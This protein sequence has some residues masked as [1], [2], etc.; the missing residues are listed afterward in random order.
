MKL[1]YDCL[2]V[3]RIRDYLH[4]PSDVLV[5][6]K[7]NLNNAD[8]IDKTREPAGQRSRSLISV[9][10]LV[11]IP[12]T[13][14]S[15]DPP[16]IPRPSPSLQGLSPATLSKPSVEE[17]LQII[18]RPVDEEV[19]AIPE[20]VEEPAS[21]LVEGP[22]SPLEPLGLDFKIPLGTGNG[23]LPLGSGYLLRHV[24]L[25]THGVC[26]HFSGTQLAE[27]HRRKPVGRVTTNYLFVT[28]LAFSHAYRID[29]GLC[30]GKTVTI[31]YRGSATPSLSPSA[32]PTDTTF[33]LD[34]VFYLFGV[35]YLR[36]PVSFW[37]A[38]LGGCFNRTVPL[39]DAQDNRLDTDLAGGHPSSEDTFVVVDANYYRKC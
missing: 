28:I 36:Q 33:G 32:P 25:A 37:G 13:D 16:T 20:P 22:S 27:Y 2:T 24:F 21:P 8:G 9:S 6:N 17:P 18:V 10:T 26:M 30:A 4:Q 5:L 38:H 34:G 31:T 35:G 23:C 7:T 1:G 12:I 15:S 3:I 19:Q 29:I 14:C 39:V 11:N